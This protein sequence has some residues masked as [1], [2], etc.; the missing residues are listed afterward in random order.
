MQTALNIDFP[1]AAGKNPPA[2][3]RCHQPY[4]SIP[5]FLKTENSR[6]DE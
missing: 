4:H 6:I 1:S 5:V 2:A 3:S